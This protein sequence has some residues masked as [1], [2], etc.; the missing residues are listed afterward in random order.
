MG[1]KNR[2][3]RN[4]DFFIMVGPFFNSFIQLD[5][6]VKKRRHYKQILNGDRANR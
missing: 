1:K 5:K 3:K 6:S 2:E 4:W